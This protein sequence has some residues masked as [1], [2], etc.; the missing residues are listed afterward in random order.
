M[1]YLDQIVNNINTS[2][3]GMLSA[4]PTARYADIVSIV[5]RKK[6]KGLEYLPAEVSIKGDCKWLTFDD[7]NEL[8]LYHRIISSAYLQEK[9]KSYGDGHTSFQHNMD[10]DIVVMADRKKVG[11]TPESLEAAIASNIPITD[12]IPG[13]SYINIYPVSANHDSR[14]IFSNQFQG[15]GYYLKPEHILFSIR[16]RI[17]VKYM[18]GCIGLCHCE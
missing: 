14:T 10:L 16:Y 9:N 18:K 12:K 11:I 8:S 7:I 13:I 4:F 6:D 2:L 15:V 1:A 3:K 5:A 17:E